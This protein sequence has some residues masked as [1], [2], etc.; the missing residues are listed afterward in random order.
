MKCEPLWYLSLYSEFSSTILSLFAKTNVNWVY[1]SMRPSLY[2]QKKKQLQQLSLFSCPFRWCSGL[3]WHYILIKIIFPCYVIDWSIIDRF[4][5]YH[6]SIIDWL[7]IDWLIDWLIG[8]LVDWLIDWYRP[9]DTISTWRY[10]IDLMIRY[11]LDNMIDLTN[12]W[13]YVLTKIMI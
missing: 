11:W 1:N 10:D 4:L 12:P 3:V 2:F 5:F 6:W 8:G 7:I 13:H 9:E